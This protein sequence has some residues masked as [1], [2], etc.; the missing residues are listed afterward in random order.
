MIN[1]VCPSCHNWRRH[2]RDRFCGYCGDSFVL[3][4]AQVDPQYCYLGHGA[5]AP[6]RI[7]VELDNRG[8]ID[9][10][11]NIV[12]LRSR[13]TGNELHRQIIDDAVLRNM[14][15]RWSYTIPLP[16]GSLGE[17]W[18]GELVHLV[19]GN[20]RERVLCRL[21]YGLSEAGLALRQDV[22][23]PVVHDAGNAEATLSL[24]LREGTVAPITKIVV[25]AADGHEY[26]EMPVFDGTVRHLALDVGTELPVRLRLPRTLTQWLQLQPR[27]ARFYLVVSIAG[28]PAAKRLP[29]LLRFQTPASPEIS[30]PPRITALAR[31]TARLPLTVINHGGTHCVMD[32]VQLHLDVRA[33]G[34]MPPV[35]HSFYGEATI[36]APGE[37]RTVAIV[38]PLRT[39]N[40]PLPEGRTYFCRVDLQFA[41]H[42]ETLSKSNVAIEVRPE[43]PFNGYIAI[44]FGTSETAVAY[45]RHDEREQP[46]PLELEPGHPFVPT[47]ICYYLNSDSTLA[48]CIG[49]E[50][51]QRAES[52]DRGVLC[53]DSL[54]WRIGSTEFLSL[55]DG[56][57]VSWV[58]VAADYLRRLKELIEEHPSIAAVVDRAYPSR[59]A[60]F[61]S[62]ATAGLRAAFSRAGIEPMVIDATGENHLMLSES[63]APLMLA[64]PLPALVAMQ[65]SAV[66]EDLIAPPY[67]GTHH[68]LTFDVGGGSTDVSLFAIDVRNRANIVVRELATDGSEKV[69][70]N[71]ITKLLY[72]HLLPS[73]ERW[74]AQHGVALKRV[75][76]HLPWQEIPH[77]GIDPRAA[78]NGR[79][80][81]RLLRSLQH[82]PAGPFN[83]LYNTFARELPLVRMLQGG[84]DVK[85]QEWLAS[86]QSK[87]FSSCVLDGLPLVLESADGTSLKIHWERDGLNLDLG[88]F[89]IDYQQTVESR[90]IDLLQSV[91]TDAGISRDAPLIMLLTGRGS[92]F[93]FY[94]FPMLVRVIELLN[95]TNC[96]PVR[97][98]WTFRKGITCIGSLF[99]ADLVLNSTGII[100]R[101]ETSTL[102]G[103]LGDPDQRT[104]QPRFLPLCTGYPMPGDGLKV[105]SRPMRP[106]NLDRRI[107]LGVASR[108]GDMVTSRFR[109]EYVVSARVELSPDE[110]AKAHIVVDAIK[111]HCL[112][113]GIACP[114]SCD[115]PIDWST[116]RMITIDTIELVAGACSCDRQEEAE[117]PSVAEMVP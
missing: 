57:S 29:V 107:E 3:L 38:L 101:S 2:Q 37:E 106:G 97:T 21:D 33:H 1:P 67:V 86:Y 98:A 72:K 50:A 40:G 32:K 20:H 65:R 56:R 108:E 39:D 8:L 52:G 43:R 79:A 55:P 30:V 94:E 70:G 81:A 44:D 13:D 47:T 112:R 89:I 24:Y 53:L 96:N 35:E 12:I 75:P 4:Q 62:P 19:P 59:P 80:I 92:L 115:E 14:N 49:Q 100:F 116:A 73:L 83:D 77:G 17:R 27:G 10:V 95:L 9:A 11:G 22:V 66:G 87:Y 16:T 90:L 110:A 91:L 7:S 60:R 46:H 85:V 15:D 28:L 74:A 93:T 36:L 23:E 25:E 109:S 111:E 88:A 5:P 102:F 99:L 48:Y 34:R 103:T 63:W 54:K 68:I 45:L 114:Q 69:C 18:H 84:D 82:G 31:R 78:A 42:Q 61:S 76:V 6:D 26:P 105:V 41:D 113:I 71:A 117:Q 58:D 51:R 104:G 64:L